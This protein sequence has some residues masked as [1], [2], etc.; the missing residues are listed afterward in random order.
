[1]RKSLLFVLF[2]CMH[3]IIRGQNTYHYEYWFDND[4]TT[5]QIGTSTTNAWQ[6]DVDL[7]DLNNS[8]HTVHLQ[9]KD[10]EGVLSS[11]VSRHFV[12]MA[13]SASQM[14]GYYW[15]D[16]DQSTMKTS[17]VI[18]GTFDVDASMLSEGYHTFHYQAIDNLGSASSVV[19]SLI[20]KEF[21]TGNLATFRCWFDNNY[22]TMQDGFP[23]DDVAVLDVSALSD[24]FHVVHVQ[25]DGIASTSPHSYYFIKQP[26]TKGVE[27][28][29]LV[30]S[31]D[32][33]LY[34]QERVS[35]TGGAMLWDFDIS[36]L[37]QGLHHIQLLGVT[38]SG[39]ATSSY[40]TFFIR[41]TTQEEIEDMKFYYYIDN[42]NFTVY[43]GRYENGG[44]H[45]DLDV[46][47][48]SD[49]LHRLAYFM[50]NGKGITTTVTSQFFWKTPV[51]GNGIMEYK[52]W[53]NDKSSEEDIQ[54]VK[55]AERTNP[56]QLI[57]L[58]PV[59]SQPLRSSC[60][61]FR[62]RNGLPIIYAKNDI[63]IR[64]TEATGRFTD[65]SKQFVDESVSQEVEPVGELQE[66]QTFDRVEEN[67]IRW[68]TINLEEGDSVAF[69]SSQACTIQLF[70]PSGEEVYSASGS[71]SVTMDG[72]HSR[73]DGTYYLAVHDVT[74][75]QSHITLDYNHIDKYAVLAYTPDVIGVAESYIEMRLE[76]NGYDRLE[77]VILRANNDVVQADSMLVL[78]KGKS[79]VRFPFYGDEALGKYDLIVRFK[80]GDL[81]DS[82]VCDRA[83]T[84]EKE[85]MADLEVRVTSP[86]SVAYPYPVTISVTNPGNVSMLYVPFNIA[87]TFDL[88]GWHATATLGQ[89][90]W[91]SMV[92][93]NFS[94]V[95]KTDYDPIKNEY[96]APYNPYTVTDDLFG[97]GIPGVVTHLFIPNLGPHE[98]KEFVVGFIGSGHAKFNL[99]AWTGFPMN[100]NFD[101]LEEETNIY[102]VWK[103]L[104]EFETL[105]KSL[106]EN[107]SRRRAALDNLGHGG[108]ALDV[109]DAISDQIPGRAGDAASAGVSN[110]RNAL[111]IGLTG[112][113]IINSAR[114]HNLHQYTDNDWF[115]QQTLQDYQESLEQNMPTPAQIANIGG[116]PDWL[117]HLL[118]L[119][120]EQAT[121]G[122]PMPEAHEIE[123]WTPGDPNDIYGYTAQSGSKAI[124]K[125]VTNGYYTV[126]FE[127]DPKLANAAAHTIVV[128]DTLNS[129]TFD[130]STFEPTSIKIGHVETKVSKDTRF[131]FTIDFRPN[132][133]VIGQV[134]LN[135]DEKK[136]IATWTISSLDPMTMEETNDAMQG[137]L[138]VNVNGNGQGELAFDIQFKSNLSQ[139]T[140]IK[141]RASIVFD[142]EKPILTPMW[143]NVI[144][145]IAPISHVSACEIKNDT[146]VVLRYES[147]DELSGVWKYDV[148]AQY[149]EDAPWKNV[150]TIAA[151]SVL[152]V[153]IYEGI[154][155]GFYVV[156]TDSAGNVEMKEAAREYTLD[157]FE[158]TEDSDLELELAEG[159]NWVSHN[160]NTS[161]DVADVQTHAKRIL[162]QEEETIK[163][164]A[165]GFVGDLTELKPTL[166][167]KILVDADDNVALDGKLYNASYKSIGLS[168]GWNW[169]GYPLAH[170]M[171]I[172][173]AL[174]NFTPEEGD[175]II[176]QDDFTQYAD[177]EWVGTLS[178]LTPGLGYLYKSG[179]TKQMFFNSTATLSSRAEAQRRVAAIESPWSCDKHKYPNVMA[180]TACLYN[181]EMAEDAG[182]YYVAAFCDNE[183]R[184]VGKTVKGLVMMNVYGQGNETI[185]F[186][187]I[188]K[189]TEQL[190]D[191]AENVAFN[192]DVQGSIAA[193]FRMTIGDGLTTDIANRSDLQIKITPAVIRNTMTVEIGAERIDRLTVTSMNGAV[194]ANWKKLANGSTVDVSSLTAG[195]YVVT[196][197]AG[198]QVFTKKVMKVTE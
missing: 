143:V 22:S 164:A 5:L 189:E 142:N 96:Y 163:D 70:A 58:L 19:T 56:Y 109:A 48:L 28:I 172:A 167:Y 13:P 188:D 43:E 65:V 97:M 160:L 196:V 180:V 87:C 178:T 174:E 1:M 168:E 76:G 57:T 184:G 186:K 108:R 166:G 135:Y 90:A 176:G 173:Q 7:T 112:G 23:V 2:L 190:M 33:V 86:K 197:K 144:D 134:D 41:A 81:M 54:V 191:I 194:V 74:G 67:G 21:Q 175:Y 49:G 183:C 102:S 59:E 34:K 69:K 38:P 82:I 145:A 46:S 158:P 40:T 171:E 132:I 25:A 118:G 51:G 62:M 3:H 138:P 114:L 151:D 52:Y 128:K 126:E 137:V 198:K 192:A 159:W 18:N 177:G 98:T 66:T 72:C 36:D 32:G 89:S 88:L 104:R 181:N 133:D 92:P 75:S 187:V 60:F 30:C 31:I 42:D 79:I 14:K 117:S 156:A 148:Y 123:I 64:F 170:E 15:F 113:G 6:M 50:S 116:L 61:E 45:F 9:V 101:D 12:K 47:Q 16:N 157:L 91:A 154:N 185:Q 4:R 115:A 105:K 10:D 146:T 110:A 94:L 131:P 26:Q 44:F 124:G 63:H 80:D 130:L 147:S 127:N 17:D 136:G 68:Y 182:D 103:Y 155:H 125:G 193:P 141:N 37:K 161:V 179:A 73:E 53:L 100:S 77:D 29:T 120:G 153:R 119:Q 152:D 84:L 35:N 107:S 162:G 122:H 129:A 20:Y 149:G 8:F 95:Y 55:L 39:A 24:G 111:G 85:E 121:C 93:M 165:F 150:G 99:Y 169:I 71:Q 27:Y 78:S 195:V 140:K 139:G 11:P 106:S 83:I